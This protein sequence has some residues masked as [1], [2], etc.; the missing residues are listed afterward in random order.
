MQTEHSSIA[1]VEVCVCSCARS[2]LNN[3]PKHNSRYAFD[4]AHH[5]RPGA[6]VDQAVAI[7]PPRWVKFEHIQNRRLSN[8]EVGELRARGALPSDNCEGA[9][10]ARLVAQNMVHPAG[11]VNDK[12]NNSVCNSDGHLDLVVVVQLPPPAAH[13]LPFRSPPPRPHRLVAGPAA[14]A[15]DTL[16]RKAD[17]FICVGLGGG[18][19]NNNYLLKS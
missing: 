8:D 18:G 14:A 1:Y 13:Q 9:F 5:P 4:S 3:L 10:L 6:L 7:H 2:S 15:P 17:I 12:L 19:D 16:D 11:A